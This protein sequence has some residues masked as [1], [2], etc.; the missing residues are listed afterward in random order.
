MRSVCD[1]LSVFLSFQPVSVTRPQGRGTAKD[2][3][4]DAAAG[5]RPTGDKRASDGETATEE[6]AVKGG[7]DAKIG[8]DVTHA[9]EEEAAAE[10]ESET[11]TGNPATTGRK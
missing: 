10:V 9:E 1:V 11:L 3:A 8:R 6:N 5:G 2:D 7:K 4:G